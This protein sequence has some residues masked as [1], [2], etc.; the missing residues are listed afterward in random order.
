MMSETANAPAPLLPVWQTFKT[1]Y[2]ES[3]GH[4]GRVYLLAWQPFAIAVFITFTTG[5]I[6][7]FLRTGL[8][9]T[10]TFGLYASYLTNAYFTL[11]FHRYQLFGWSKETSRLSFGFG[12]AERVF[13]LFATLTYLVF[14][15]PPVLL[16]RAGAIVGIMVWTAL[17]LCAVPVCIGLSLCFPAAADG[18]PRPVA[19]GWALGQ[20]SW[21]RL[22]GLF[23]LCLIP[24]ALVGALI[25]PLE[26]AHPAITPLI[27][28]IISYPFSAAVVTAICTSYKIKMGTRPREMQ[29]PP[30]PG[31]QAAAPPAVPPNA[32]SRPSN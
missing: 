24:P 5:F 1:A 31:P 14:A 15:L 25:A 11:A 7:G 30:E 4:L 26:K 13:L 28:G 32:W 9:L 23:V 19:L 16:D 21:A 12:R 2:R 17:A 29:P 18:Q 10:S 20:G 6:D 3:F 27:N 8:L 22:L